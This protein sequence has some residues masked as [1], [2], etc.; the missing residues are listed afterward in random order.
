MFTRLNRPESKPPARKPA[1][2]ADGTAKSAFVSRGLTDPVRPNENGKK[3]TLRP[4]T[5]VTPDNAQSPAE[6]AVNDPVKETE[7]NRQAAESLEKGQAEPVQNTGTRE[8]VSSAEPTQPAMTVSETDIQTEEK[9]TQMEAE[10]SAVSASFTGQT[11]DIPEPETEQSEEGKPTGE[12]LQPAPENPA[13]GNTALNKPGETGDQEAKATEEKT[14]E[15]EKA[16]EPGN[17]TENT[18][19][20]GMGE[21]IIEN[22]PEFH[23][24]SELNKLG[25]EIAQA[26]Q[27]L[28]KNNELRKARI[29]AALAME[30][31]RTGLAATREI[32]RTETQYDTAIVQV[33]E[34]VNIQKRRIRQERSAAI[35]RVK[36]LTYTKLDALDTLI[37]KKQQ[38]MLTSGKSYATAILT[39]RDRLKRTASEQNTAQKKQMRDKAK[40]I[41]SRKKY[42]GKPDKVQLIREDLT[43]MVEGT[44]EKIS[45]TVYD[46]RSTLN[47]DAQT[48]ADEFR[49]EAQES[50]ES[51]PEGSEDVEQSFKDIRD[52]V[53]KN[54]RTAGEKEVAQL[55]RRAEDTIATLRKNKKDAVASLRKQKQEA[56]GA[57]DEVAAAVYRNMDLAQE[58]TFGV[59]DAA[60]EDA[61]RRAPDLP[62]ELAAEVVGQARATKNNILYADRKNGDNIV[63]QA[64]TEMEKLRLAVSENIRLAADS[65]VQSASAAVKGYKKGMKQMADQI[66]G[67]FTKL[68]N[69][70]NR[71]MNKALGEFAKGLN[72]A[73][74]DANKK[75][76]E[77]LAGGK[78]ELYDKTVGVLSENQKAVN[79]TMAEMPGRAAYL[80]KS[81]KWD[82]FWDNVGGFFE[83]LWEGLLEFVSALLTIFKWILIG[84]AVLAALVLLV[85]AVAALIGSGAFLAVLG[86]IASVVGAIISAV[87]AIAG[88]VMWIGIAV[89][90]GFFA[91]S[92]YEAVTTKGLRGRDR[93]KIIGKGTFD[94]VTSFELGWLKNVKF[95]K[96]G[97][98]MSKWKN[99]LGFFGKSKAAR[100]FVTFSNRSVDL[101]NGLVGKFT[102]EVER[103]QQ[104][105]G[106]FLNGL[107]MERMLAKVGG[108]AQQLE[109]LMLLAGEDVTLL[110]K[111]LRRMSPDEFSDAMK[112]YDDVGKMLDDLKLHGGK[113]EF[114]KSI[115]RREQNISEKDIEFIRGKSGS[116]FR[117][118]E[119]LLD[120]KGIIDEFLAKNPDLTK[121]E[122]TAIYRYTVDSDPINNPLKGLPPKENKVL[123][124]IDIKRANTFEKVMNSGLKKMRLSHG[125]EGPVFKGGSMKESDLLKKYKKGASISEKGFYSASKEQRVADHFMNLRNKPG[126]V[127]VKFFI[128]TKGASYI[129]D[130][131][132]FSK[133]F[134]DVNPKYLFDQ[135]EILFRSKTEFVIV[136]VKKVIEDNRSFYRIFLDQ[137]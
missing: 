44:E 123:T 47:E 60:F 23:T 7:I 89:G 49:E 75:W 17:D 105:A 12:S 79:D 130:L 81:S 88:V 109:K 30:K 134:E 50:A 22:I 127:K 63:V 99:I 124:I 67:G 90:V 42:S 103:L 41:W 43:D 82:R 35:T 86:A 122:I 125:Y 97:P 48:M 94:L 24:R 20:A 83:G 111:G 110:Q 25:V 4:L 95:L 104:L 37:D 68:E 84:L 69:S 26:K 5:V 9:D 59:M 6:N 71:E 118:A 96:A 106:K 40:E 80:W 91:F 78:R 29:S 116:S 16:E 58:K 14:E 126:E 32:Q 13:P 100:K 2:N 73:L 74:W 52:E 114:F 38:R 107:Q 27:A 57:L 39:Y 53:V 101:A 85:L 65:C 18:A 113:D 119:Q 115:K 55:D 70:A 98:K 28:S 121:E 8:A 19:D 36:Q 72:E 61:D 112:H 102:G 87:G 120:K 92:I 108:D 136:D 62:D 93:W 56:I 34:E 15:T 45:G 10:K 1:N 117:R 46:L 66:I 54:L 11:A 31:V 128:N 137:K 64:R 129:N 132:H 133:R 21:L 76:D 3:W 51:L 131:S 33:R 135:E 77:K